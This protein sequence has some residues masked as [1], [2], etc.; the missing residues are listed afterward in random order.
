MNALG[1]ALD[2]AYDTLQPKQQYYNRYITI[3]ADYG[4]SAA[5]FQTASDLRIKRD[6]SDIKIDF[7]C[8]SKIR[9]VEYQYRDHMVSGDRH[10]G[11]IAQEVMKVLPTAVS[12]SSDYIPNV[13]K[14]VHVSISGTSAH[15]LLENH[16]MVVGDKVRLLSDI[17]PHE[18]EVSA[19]HADKVYFK[20]FTEN[21]VKHGDKV[22][23][24]GKLVN[25]YLTV[26]YNQLA[27]YNLKHTQELYKTIQ[28]QAMMLQKM[29][30][31]ISALESV[32]NF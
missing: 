1:A 5:L 19:V 17:G 6:V 11:V 9:C 26:D 13:L 18:V 30:D 16:D 24:Y 28:E 21:C 2:Q 8:H 25:D 3:K 15:I 29:N 32:R 7:D 22:V 12:Y 4:V 23:V 31:R 14:M 27:I 10:I 20:G